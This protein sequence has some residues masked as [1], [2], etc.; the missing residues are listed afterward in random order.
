MEGGGPSGARI[1]CGHPSGTAAT[2]AGAGGTFENTADGAVSLKNN[3]LPRSP[4]AADRF[5]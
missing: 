3:K 5:V 4:L 1:I 2:V